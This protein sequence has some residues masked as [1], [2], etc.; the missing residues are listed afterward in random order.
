VSRW[1][2]LQRPEALTIAA[3]LAEAVELAAARHHFAEQVRW[4]EAHGLLAGRLWPD[5][6]GPGS[7][8]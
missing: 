5:L 8:S 3:A 1:V 4:E 7:T 2:T 6:P